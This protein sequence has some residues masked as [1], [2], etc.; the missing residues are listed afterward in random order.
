[1]PARSVTNLGSRLIRSRPDSWW[2]TPRSAA[3]VLLVYGAAAIAGA[4]VFLLCVGIL[5]LFSD[6]IPAGVFAPP[7][8]PKPIIMPTSPPDT[9]NQDLIARVKESLKL[10]SIACSTTEAQPAPSDHFSE[11]TYT[12]LEARDVSNA[13]AQS[14][15]TLEPAK[16]LPCI[17]GSLNQ[18]RDLGVD[19]NLNQV[20]NLKFFVSQR[21]GQ[22]LAAAHVDTGVSSAFS[23]C[24]M[25]PQNEQFVPETARL[26]IDKGDLNSA[27]ITKS[28]TH[29]IC[30]SGH[31]TPKSPIIETHIEAIKIT[32]IDVP[33]PPTNL[34]CEGFRKNSDGSWTAAHPKPFDIGNVRQFRINNTTFAYR[35][36]SIG[37]VDLAS[38][39]DKKCGSGLQ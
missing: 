8:T 18:L 23:Y 22:T 13:L 33:M 1:M 38:F 21:A 4:V 28:D 24:V 31:S 17:R 12:G 16:N 10:I 37:G 30:A 19:Q 9:L 34:N 20:F 15:A 2:P 3:R 35:A 25:A 32:K 11:V 26:V 27:H 14:V 39:L 6:N 7:R 36:F 5:K 29:Q